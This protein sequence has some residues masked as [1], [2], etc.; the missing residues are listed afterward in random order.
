M[1]KKCILLG[2][3]PIHVSN[4]SKWIY[5]LCWF[6]CLPAM[7]IV[8]LLEKYSVARTFS[9]KKKLTKNK[10]KSHEI[11]YYKH[12]IYCCAAIFML[13]LWK[14]SIFVQKFSL[15][16]KFLSKSKHANQTTIK[17]RCIFEENFLWKQQK[18]EDKQK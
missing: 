16:W 5:N 4:R 3:F 17:T 11:D 9:Y 15:L 6:V 13:L 10:H 12:S 2:F 18:Y 8:I 1:K 14:K 7:C